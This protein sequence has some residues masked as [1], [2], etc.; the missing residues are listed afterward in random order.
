M[1]LL[2]VYGVTF[3][4]KDSSSHDVP[5]TF[6]SWPSAQHSYL[7]NLGHTLGEAQGG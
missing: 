6:T 4:N 3:F 7:P 2:D 5:D 1:Y